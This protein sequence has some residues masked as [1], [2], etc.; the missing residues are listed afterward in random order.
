VIDLA[1][2]R[3]TKNLWT[4]RNGG[5]RL[6]LIAV[7]DEADQA[8]YVE[9]VLESREAGVKLKQQPVCFGPP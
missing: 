8:R 6:Q 2:E 9:R 3:F 5:D 4:E 1:S 7:G